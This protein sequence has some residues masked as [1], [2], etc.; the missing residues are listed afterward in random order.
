[1]HPA[2]DMTGRRCGRLVVIKR[3]PKA[4][5]KSW[6]RK[7]WW[8]CKCDCGAIINAEGNKLRRGDTQSCGCLQIDRSTVHGL[9]EAPE[10]D[11]WKGMRQRCNNPTHYSYP[12]YG[13]RGISVCPEWTDFSVFLRD[14]GS[15]PSPIHTIDRINN[16]GDYSK[17]NCRWATR[18][19]Q[20]QN[21]RPWG[22]SQ[23]EQS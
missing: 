8:T 19:E 5:Q 20:S 22:T 9:R 11:V 15:R 12:L 3:A 23:R 14:M 13:G 21:K 10:Y 1:M 16:D 18:H 6:S 4:A 2:T 7:A 17:A